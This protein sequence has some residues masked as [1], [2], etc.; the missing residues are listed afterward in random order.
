MQKVLLW[1]K[2]QKQLLPPFEHAQTIDNAT[3]WVCGN[4][5]MALLA[6]DF[7]RE[8][9]VKVPEDISVC[10]FDDIMEAHFEGLTSYRFKERELARALFSHLTNTRL[11][12]STKRNGSVISVGGMVVDRNTTGSVRQSM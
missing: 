5:H 2:R 9:G 12:H 4:D 8:L 3:A 11:F 10:G 6:L 7:L 1:K